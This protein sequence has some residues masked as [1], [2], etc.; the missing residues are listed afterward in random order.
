MVYLISDVII[1]KI[2]MWLETIKI[3]L[4]TL[5]FNNGLPYPCLYW[6]D[7]LRSLQVSCCEKKSLAKKPWHNLCVAEV[8]GLLWANYYLSHRCLLMLGWSLGMG[9]LWTESSWYSH[10]LPIAANPWYSIPYL[11]FGRGLIYGGRTAENPI[12]FP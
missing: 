8:V 1:N 5:P 11:S 9:L 6:R 4:S 3:V 7:K 12:H 2:D 10:R